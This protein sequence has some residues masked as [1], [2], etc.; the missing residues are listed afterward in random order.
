MTTYL[1]RLPVEI[2]H[3]IFEF[4]SNSD[5]L[6]SF[7][8][9]SPYLNAVL[10]HHHWH[11]LN[12]Q[13]ISKSRFD[14]ICN[15]LELQRIISL[16]LSNDIKTPGQIQLFFSQFNL[17]DFINL[18]SLT[19][20][21][22]TYEEIYPILSD[23]SKL[24]HLTSLITTCRSSEPLLIG[25]TL[26]QLK[27][28][29]NL[30]ISYGDIFDHN[31]TFPL[32]NLTI[33]DAGTCNFLELR[34]LQWIV[35]SL[36]SL[37]IILEANHQ[38]QLVSDTNGWSCLKRLNLTLKGEK[39]TFDEMQ[40]FLY[41]FHNLTHLTL[42]IRGS[43]NEIAN[44]YHW[45]KCSTIASLKKFDFIFEFELS[46]ANSTQV[47][48]EIFTSFSTPFWRDI[49]KWYVAITSH[50]VY[51]ISC[52]DDQLFVSSTSS[53]LTTSP[54]D[55]WFYSKVKRIEIDKNTSI[56][57]LHHFHKLE[58]LDLLEEKLF[59]STSH[60]NKFAFLR[61]LSFH[62]CI[63]NTILNEIL[64]YNPNIN[65]LTLSQIDFNQ[66]LPLKTI[67]YLYLEDSIKITNRTQI[68][69]LHRIFPTIK[70]L[71]IY[72]NSIQLICQIIN[73][74]HQLENIRFHFYT[75]IKPISYQWLKN[76][77]RLNKNSCSFTYQNESQE[78]LLWINNSMTS[79]I[80][81][82]G[83]LSINLNVVQER[84]SNQCL[85]Q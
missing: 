85:L 82:E 36:V 23:L 7:Y 65:H 74:F 60:M 41:R 66:L 52:F 51:T 80:H 27:S 26:T 68:K 56:I 14:F 33:L 21:S 49:K 79:T 29:K 43:V 13:S 20:L 81:S 71:S 32:H 19:L 78:I 75:I 4:M 76:N 44:G 37:K 40:T 55:S 59:L 16:T 61:H 47:M 39:T 72:L 48:D 22:I 64:T 30:S 67:H 46:S 17:R 69:E 42:N 9:I 1:D 34:R 58:R 54:D 12:F 50:N 6:W 45:E 25:Q 38:L 63:S 31:V 11:T 57:N 28:L 83:E 18:H 3:M 10:N 73:D 70:Q 8:N 35:P 2:L 15:H 5:V 84:R 24:K 62:Q 77:T 53:P